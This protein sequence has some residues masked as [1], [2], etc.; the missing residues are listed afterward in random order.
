[1][2]VYIVIR[3]RRYHSIHILTGTSTEEVTDSHWRFIPVIPAFLLAVFKVFYCALIGCAHLF[4][5]EY[6][7]LLIGYN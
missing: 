2:T 3:H 5:M 1:M 4:S 6:T 7:C